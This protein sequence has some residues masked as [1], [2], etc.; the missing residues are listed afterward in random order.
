MDSVLA[1]LRGLADERFRDDPKIGLD[2]ANGAVNA[3]ATWGKLAVAATDAARRDAAIGGM[4]SVLAYLRGLADK[5][6][7]N[8]R[9]IGLA[10][11]KG[12]VNA[13]VTFWKLGNSVGRDV[14]RNWLRELRDRHFHPEISF[15]AS[16]MNV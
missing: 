4:D 12:A 7:R 11:A 15:L 3:I 6:F 9:E 8:D 10:A 2:A 1:Y 13:G 5:R 14:C 16:K